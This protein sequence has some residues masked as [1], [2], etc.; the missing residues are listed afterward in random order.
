MEKRAIGSREWNLGDNDQIAPAVTCARSLL[1]TAAA[2]WVDSR[3]LGSVWKAIKADSAKQGPTLEHWEALTLQIWQMMWGGK[4]DN[5]VPDLPK[6]PERLQ[7]TNVLGSIE[8]LQR[9][10]SATLQSDYQ[11]LCNAAHRAS[12]IC[13]PLR[14]R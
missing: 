2:F 7:R 12:E 1:E 9:V 13:S 3:K 8:K 10:T 14:L 11:W 5:K 6:M 4:F